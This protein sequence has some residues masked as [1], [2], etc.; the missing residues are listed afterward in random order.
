MPKTY[1]ITG[2]SGFVGSELA[3]SLVW[4]NDEGRVGTNRIVALVRD[5]EPTMPLHDVVRGSVDDERAVKR[6]L[7][8]G[9]YDGIFHLAASAKVEVCAANPLEAWDTNVRGTYTLLECANRLTCPIVVASSDHAY[10][11]SGGRKFS[12]DDPYVSG[13]GIYDVSKSCT[14]MI[15]MCYSRMADV[16][17]VRCGNIYGPSDRDT[18]RLIPSILADLWAGRAPTIRSDGTAVREFLHITDAVAAYKAVLDKG[19]AGEAYNFAG[20]KAWSVSDVVR[21][22]VDIWEEIRLGLEDRKAYPSLYSPRFM[23][24]A[25]KVVVLGTRK[26]ELS[27]LTLNDN[28]AFNE[29]GWSTKVTL[30]QG[31]GDMIRHTLWNYER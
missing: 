7:A 27:R 5:H 29:L 1:L 6:A 17:V 23:P 14:D 26:G 10:G 16:R 19:Q 22:I 3:H 30:K 4:S 15:A 9:P 11:V 25:K 8:M 24:P 12:E 2:A 28:K 31:I 20:D 21:Q 13:G 18:S